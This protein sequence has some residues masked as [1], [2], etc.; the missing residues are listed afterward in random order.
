MATES[1]PDDIDLDLDDGPAPCS[2]HLH[3][4]DLD[5]QV[6]VGTMRDG[7]YFKY[8]PRRQ[9]EVAFYGDSETASSFMVWRNEES[10]DYDFV[11]VLAF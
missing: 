10:H 8:F 4:L 5:D 9:E 2:L 1:F 7:K 6:A 3:K 11:S